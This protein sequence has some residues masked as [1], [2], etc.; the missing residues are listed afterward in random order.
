MFQQAVNGGSLMIACWAAL[1][2]E[3]QRAGSDRCGP[4]PSASARGLMPLGVEQLD[5]GREITYFLR[6]L[7]WLDPSSR[8]SSDMVEDSVH[9]V[10]STVWLIGTGATASILTEWCPGASERL[11]PTLV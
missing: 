2:H 11:V 1:Q 3:L 5:T 8:R 6:S 10:G 4:A 7:N 9:S